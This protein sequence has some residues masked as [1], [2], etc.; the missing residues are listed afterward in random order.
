MTNQNVIDYTIVLSDNDYLKVTAT[1]IPTIEDDIWLR[2]D[3]QDEDEIFVV[4]IN[5]VKYFKG[6]RRNCKKT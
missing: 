2:F 3:T 6:I 5:L 4:N 1:D